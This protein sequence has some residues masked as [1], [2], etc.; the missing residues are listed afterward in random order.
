MRL[1]P[2]IDVLAGN[3]VRLV[4]GD[5]QAKKVY[6]EDPLAAA[7]AWVDAGAEYLHMVDLDGARSGRPV[8][9]EQL[10]R[11]ASEAGVPVQYGGGLRSAE[12][13]DRA[14]AAGAARVILGTVAFTDPDVLARSLE[15]HGPERVLVGVDV[16]AGHVATHG[17]LQSTDVKARD[18]FA[19]LRERGVR[20]FV[21]TNIDHDGML[22]GASREEVIAVAEAVGEGSVIFSGGIGSREHLGELAG[23]RAELALEG[24]DGVIVGTALY[25]RRFTVAEAKEALALP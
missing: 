14:L 21:F 9:L 18:A 3:A 23:L 11:V 25:E 16:R 2:A 7:R 13:V 22:D 24:L 8:N 17:W 19:A 1:Y 4:R 5:F 12:A 15:A 20:N 10:A 6:D